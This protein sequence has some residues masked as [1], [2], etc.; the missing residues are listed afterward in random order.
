[1]CLYSAVSAHE[2]AIGLNVCSSN[3][4]EFATILAEVRGFLQDARADIVQMLRV[5]N[6][7]CDSPAVNAF[8]PVCI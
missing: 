2:D 3:R 1:V 8:I 6:S 7:R 4:G 5:L